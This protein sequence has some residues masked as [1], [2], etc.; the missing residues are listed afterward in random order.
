MRQFFYNL[1][2]QTATRF[3]LCV[4]VGAVYLWKDSASAES[5]AIASFCIVLAVAYAIDIR[6]S[7]MH[8]D[9]EETR[10]GHGLWRE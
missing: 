4:I 10:R 3:W 8:S 2:R 7:K 6:A 5:M 9:D 1:F